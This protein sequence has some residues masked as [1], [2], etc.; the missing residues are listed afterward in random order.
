MDQRIV[1]LEIRIAY[2]E[3]TIHDLDEMVTKYAARLDALARE[4]AELRARFDSGSDAPPIVD[5]PPPHY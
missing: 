1:E 5:E 4:L 3:K 2:Q